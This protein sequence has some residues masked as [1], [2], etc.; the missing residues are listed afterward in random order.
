[1][2]ARAHDTKPIDGRAA[3]A[4]AVADALSGRCFAHDTL[5]AL[6]AGG[7][8][9][10]REGGLATEIAQGTV[11]H[12]VTIEQL[13]NA[14]A[15]FDRRRTVPAARAALC[16][17][18]YQI[19]WM[20]RVPAFAA[21][22]QAVDLARQLVG[23]RTPGMVN[24]I[25]R[26]LASAI[27]ERRTAWRAR[28]PTQ[29]RVDWGHACQFRSPVLPAAGS[30]E[31]NLAHLAVATGERLR[32]YRTLVKR[33]GPRQAESVAWASQAVPVTVLQR[34]PLRATT[35]AIEYDLGAATQHAAEFAHDAA[36][37]PAATPIVD[38]PAFRDGLVYVQDTTAHAAVVAVDAQRGEKILDLCAAPGGK[39]VALAVA[40]HDWGRI[41][42]CDADP[43]RLR[44]IDANTARLGLTCVRTRALGSNRPD[45]AEEG[46]VFDAAVVDV[47]CS[48][49]GVIARRPEARLGLTKAKLDSLVVLQQRLLRQAAD[50]IRPGGRLVYSTCS[51]EPE[52]NQ[53]VVAELVRE[54]PAWRLDVERTTLPAWGPR[55]ADWR[56][57]G[58]FARLVR[59]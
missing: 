49:S 13:L 57:G 6:R 16:T 51:I 40:M 12:L 41:V 47:P 25:L 27:V 24:A 32:R 14:V 42:A 1:M 19:V 23:G 29:V 34:N 37:V 31:H 10:G 22:D 56:D 11:R 17:A 36:F 9:S 48:N 4:I 55:L 43:Q 20:D 38:L 52:E 50:R 7:E 45:L 15:R 33:L 30:D 26:R 8:L 54:C 2:N 18:A 44:Q 21:V 5:R 39:S 53:Q 58:Y 28:E 35:E 3:A 46:L 59:A